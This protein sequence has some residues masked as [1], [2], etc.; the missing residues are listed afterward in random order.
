[1]TLVD[2]FTKSIVDYEKENYFENELDLETVEKDYPNNMYVIDYIEEIGHTLEEYEKI[3]VF[4]DLLEEE[5]F[6]KEKYDSIV[7]N[8]KNFLY[9]LIP[10]MPYIEFCFNEY[11]L[12]CHPELSC[13]LSKQYRNEHKKGRS[14]ELFRESQDID[15]LL[16]L[17]FADK[18]TAALIDNKNKMVIYISCLQNALVCLDESRIAG[19][20]A[21]LADNNLFLRKHPCAL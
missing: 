21:E 19:L 16:D 1:M 13:M 14:I 4:Y 17:C 3:E 8:W 10:N 18:I 5:P 6:K 7:Q 20:K 9:D 2:V 12:D 15:I 11:V